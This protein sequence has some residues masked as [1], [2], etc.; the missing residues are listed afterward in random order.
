MSHAHGRG[1][2]VAR[3]GPT[4]KAL[5]TA[6]ADA[7]TSRESWWVGLSREQFSQALAE[8]TPRMVGTLATHDN[9]GPSRYLVTKEPRP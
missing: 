8:Q 7:Q 6:V 3:H 1:I 5:R 4:T 2:R 9:A